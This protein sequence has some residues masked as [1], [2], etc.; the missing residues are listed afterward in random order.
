MSGLTATDNQQFRLLLADWDIRPIVQ[1]VLL[2]N[3]MAFG[4][5]HT[6]PLSGSATA[7]IELDLFVV[8]C[9]QSSSSLFGHDSSTAFIL[10]LWR[11]DSS[12]FS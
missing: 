9:G 5:L 6:D 3:S 2:S 11:S 7:D 12:R 4:S 10:S 1:P 8:H